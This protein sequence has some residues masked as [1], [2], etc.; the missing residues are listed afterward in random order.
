MVN[1]T[2]LPLALRQADAPAAVLCRVP[3]GGQERLTAWRGGPRPQPQQPPLLHCRLDA[4]EEEAGQ[5][6]EQ[7]SCLLVAV[8]SAWNTLPCA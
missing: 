4:R 7:A 5:G 2:P 8:R 1:D 3:P 6:G